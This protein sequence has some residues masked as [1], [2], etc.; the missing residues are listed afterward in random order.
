M[1]AAVLSPDDSYANFNPID[2]GYGF[3]LSVEYRL[4][5]SLRLSLGGSHSSYRK[6]VGVVGA[7]S[8]SFWVYEMTG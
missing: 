5:P 1:L 8:P 7:N 3:G 4:A 2:S 6:Q